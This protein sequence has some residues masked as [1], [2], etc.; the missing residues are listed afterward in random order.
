MGSVEALQNRTAMMRVTRGLSA[1]YDNFGRSLGHLNYFN[2][3][4]DIFMCDIPIQRSISIYGKGGWV[5][6]YLILG[7][8]GIMFSWIIIFQASQFFRKCLKRGKPV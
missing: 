2:S 5:F 3:D 1:A 8:T 6:P 4:E 7:L